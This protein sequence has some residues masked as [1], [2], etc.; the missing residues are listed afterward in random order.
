MTRRYRNQAAVESLQMRYHF[1]SLKVA[2]ETVEHLK[3]DISDLRMAEE[4][5]QK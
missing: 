4:T 5:N 3:N 1:L 2:L